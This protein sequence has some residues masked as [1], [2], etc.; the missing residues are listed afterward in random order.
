[1]DLLFNQGL[2]VYALRKY[3]PVSTRMQSEY[4]AEI[5]AESRVTYNFKKY[6]KNK[7]KIKRE[8]TAVYQHLGCQS[9]AVVP[10]HDKELNNLQKLLNNRVFV[11]TKKVKQRKFIHKQAIEP[12]QLNSIAFNGEGLQ[13]PVLLVDD[14]CQSGETLKFFANILKSKGFE[15]KLLV[16]GLHHKL[17]FETIEIYPAKVKLSDLPIQIGDVVYLKS[18]LLFEHPLTVVEVRQKEPD[19]VIR[20]VEGISENDK[21]IYYQYFFEGMIKKN[22]SDLRAL[23]KLNEANFADNTKNQNGSMPL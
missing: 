11:R 1:M 17:A 13:S 12:D 23:V 7:G 15:V 18:D 3:F 21:L 14:I 16:L 19:E 20:F 8:I 5:E 22:C 10:S 4:E 9:F 2:G 6:D